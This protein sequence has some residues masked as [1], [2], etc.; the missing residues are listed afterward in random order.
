[1]NFKNF[2]YALTCLSF[3]VIIGAAIYE[4][5]ALWPAAFS[6]PPKSLSVFQGPY[7][8]NAGAF[9]QSVHPVTLLLFVI[10]LIL[11]WRASRRKNVLIALV[12]YVFI[13]IATFIYFV[14][15]LLELTG[16]PYSDTV[17]P[18]LQDRG[19]L[20]ITLS[21]VRGGILIILAFNLLLGL[22]ESE[23]VIGD[24]R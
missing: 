14:P 16:T 6:E 7:R 5:I 19:S 24:K 18:S 2:L 23:K 11:N 8:L 9:W 20:W 21:L 4:H 22:T 15:E 13:L 3:S 10:T 1:M 17:D 12:G